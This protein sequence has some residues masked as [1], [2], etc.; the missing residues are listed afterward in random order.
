M[1][2]CSENAQNFTVCD[3]IFG[4]TITIIKRNKEVFKVNEKIG[5]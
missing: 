4:K 2:I 5:D 1:Q 3:R